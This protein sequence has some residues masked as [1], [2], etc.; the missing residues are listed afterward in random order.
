MR[1]LG[2]RGVVSHRRRTIPDKGT[3]TRHDL[4][5]RD[6]TN[7]VCGLAKVETEASLMC[8]GH[9][10]TRSEPAGVRGAD[11]AN[12]SGRLSGAFPGAAH[13]WYIQTGLA[14]D[15]RISATYAVT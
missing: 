3:P 11:G 4:L 1:E 13:P 12:G 15:G 9:N 7:S 14:S 8:L 6:F 5:K 10:L 2:I